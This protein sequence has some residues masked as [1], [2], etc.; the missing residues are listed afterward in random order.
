LSYLANTQTDKQTDKKQQK[1]N[2]LGGG[3]T[4]NVTRDRGEKRHSDV[5]TFEFFST[6][7][8]QT[9]QTVLAAAHKLRPELN[10]FRL[11]HIYQVFII[12][13]KL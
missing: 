10:T 8:K 4:V 13:V 9:T 7:K 5:M 12:I 6:V 1:H 3:N 11:S 2:L